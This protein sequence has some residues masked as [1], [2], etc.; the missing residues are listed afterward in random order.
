MIEDEVVM[1]TNC[2]PLSDEQWT[3]ILN[4]MDKTFSPERGIP[5][6]DLQKVWNSLLFVLN[7]GCGWIGLPKDPTFFAPR[8]TA[9]RW[10]KQWRR[11]GTF[12]KVMSGLLQVAVRQGKVDLAQMA[13]SV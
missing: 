13:V 4:L 10:L 7:R 11:D 12:D 3:L 2:H 6:S 5:R 1:S 9:H 8:S